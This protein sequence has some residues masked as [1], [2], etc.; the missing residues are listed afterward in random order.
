VQALGCIAAAAARAKFEIC[1]R[2]VP[3]L[4]FEHGV[5]LWSAVSALEAIEDVRVLA[6]L[7][8]PSRS[9]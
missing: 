8:V 1:W 9:S 4:P 5:D 2:A 6:A 3:E 7:V